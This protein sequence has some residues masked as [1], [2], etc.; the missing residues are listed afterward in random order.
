LCVVET[1]KA[2]VLAVLITAKTGITIRPA[3]FTFRALLRFL[4]RSLPFAAL[5]II[6]YAGGRSDILMLGALR[7]QAV[8]G[9]YAAADRFLIA[10]NLLAFSLYGAVLPAFAGI[11][12]IRKHKESVISALTLALLAGGAGAVVLTLSASF[13]L[14]AT[15]RFKESVGIL[16][17]LS[18]SI[19][20]L[21][22]NT[23]LGAAVF[24]RHGEVRALFILAGASLVGLILNFL[25]IPSLGAMGSAVAC[26]ITESL[27]AGGYAY[28]YFW[29]IAR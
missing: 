9:T 26:I 14:A 28:F 23:V 10:G 29:R 4:S 18:F 22:C 20:A 1:V 6:T 19:P 11:Q 8:A 15:F 2:F 5:G 3:F 25:L 7:G 12:D 16:R 27:T 24:S 17:V 13:I 21:L